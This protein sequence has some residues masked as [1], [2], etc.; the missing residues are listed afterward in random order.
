MARRYRM[1]LTKLFASD[2]QAIFDYIAAKSPQ[3]APRMI[4]RILD[5]LEGLKVIPH[6]TVVPGQAQTEPH[7][8]RSLPVGSYVIFFRVFDEHSVVRVL[9]VRHGAQRRPDHFD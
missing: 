1:L 6:R 4:S 2:L 3:N 7:P 9:R 5:A 8:V